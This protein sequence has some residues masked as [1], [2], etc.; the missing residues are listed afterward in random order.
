[1]ETTLLSELEISH[2]ICWLRGQKVLL[3][4]D[5]A[6]LYG[7]ETKQLKRQVKRNL[8]RFPADFMFELTPEEW[9]NL[10]YQSGTSSWGGIRY[11]PFAFTEQGVA[12][13]SSVIS[14]EQAIEVN[15]AIMRVFVQMRRMLEQHAD[16]QQKLDK[17]E[18]R[19]D[20]QFAV[21]FEAIRQLMQPE[22]QERK[23]IGYRV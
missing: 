16:L 3:D 23:P 21:V 14:S 15:I 13:L 2:R 19:Y 9:E 10:R 11:P 1:M 12:M 20:E 18:Q 7:I 8:S 22:M 4:F 6:S 17:L 5:I